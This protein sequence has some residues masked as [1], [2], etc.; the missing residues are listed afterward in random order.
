MNMQ[1]TRHEILATQSLDKGAVRVYPQ[2][3]TKIEYTSKEIQGGASIEEHCMHQ[4]S[5]VG[6]RL[7]VDGKRFSCRALEGSR[8]EGDTVGYRLSDAKD[9]PV[10]REHPCG[11]R[12]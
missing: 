5:A 2:F 6:M 12:K 3:G 8:S 4:I 11:S 1:S 10:W 7:A 9:G